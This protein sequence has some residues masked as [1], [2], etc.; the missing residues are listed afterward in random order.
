M[1]ILVLSCLYNKQSQ[2]RKFDTGFRALIKGCNI[3]LHDIIHEQGNG[4]N[5]RDD[6]PEKK[7]YFSHVFR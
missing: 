5:V 6:I 3:V 1:Y 2:I 7:D 4:L